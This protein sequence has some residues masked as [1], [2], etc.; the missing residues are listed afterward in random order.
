MYTKII[1]DRNINTIPDS[2]TLAKINQYTRRDFRADEV[3]IFSMKLCDNETDC[4]YE[5]FTIDALHKLAFLFLGK[6]GIINRNYTNYNESNTARIF[7]CDVCSKDTICTSSGEVYTY[8]VAQAYIPI[9]DDN[10]EI[11]KELKCGTIK[12]ISIGCAIAK[13]NCNIC[14]TDLK[15]DQC[16]HIQ[17]NTYNGVTCC[18]ILNNPTVA[19]EWSFTVK[20]NYKVKIRKITR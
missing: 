10:K 1:N 9:T 7:E 3:Y 13:L 5:R 19:Y 17:G 12:D 4:D 2:E 6:T 11:I 16:K 14:G 8:L 18:K 15:N 20:P